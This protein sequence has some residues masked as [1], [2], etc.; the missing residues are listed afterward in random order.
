MTI[1]IERKIWETVFRQETVDLAYILR[2]YGCELSN[3]IRLF[4]PL[5]KERLVNSATIMVEK[6]FRMHTYFDFLTTFSWSLIV[7]LEAI[8]K[9]TTEDLLI[10]LRLLV[11]A[12]TT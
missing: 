7:T 1:T 3:A 10:S 4:I 8:L 9:I 6:Q 12:F 11:L 2:D 5:P